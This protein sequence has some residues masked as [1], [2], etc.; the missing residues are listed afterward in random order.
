VI[1]YPKEIQDQ[2]MSDNKTM[3]HIMET[4]KKVHEQM[5]SIQKDIDQTLFS[6][7]SGTEDVVVSLNGKHELVDVK[8]SKN[9]LTFDPHALSKMV[10][11]AHEA[12]TNQIHVAT[13]ERII[14]LADK[15]SSQDD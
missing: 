4:S 2:Q 13:R 1:Q 14:S 7:S 11:E 9:S 15:L 12:A 5:E 6:A 8:F 3:Q 10:I